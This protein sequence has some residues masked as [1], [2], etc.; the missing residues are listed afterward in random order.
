MGGLML[1]KLKLRSPDLGEV[2]AS[3]YVSQYAKVQGTGLCHIGGTRWPVRAM[4]SLV[5][6]RTGRC[7]LPCMHC[8][9]R[10]GNTAVIDLHLTGSSG[11]YNARGGTRAPRDSQA[12]Y[13][14]CVCRAD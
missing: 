4:R 8:G 10:F 2:L 3:C 11:K 5:C 14:R 7:K 13:L 12:L 6:V 9:P 1:R